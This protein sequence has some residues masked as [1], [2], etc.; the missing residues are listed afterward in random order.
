MIWRHWNPDFNLIISI[1]EESAASSLTSNAAEKTEPPQTTGDA[2]EKAPA[3]SDSGEQTCVALF[4]YVSDEP[5]DLS[6]QAGETII[7]VKK[8]FKS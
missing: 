3:A 2:P 7:I 4:D 6:F 8:V 5:G 1:A